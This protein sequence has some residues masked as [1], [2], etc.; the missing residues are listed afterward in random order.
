MEKEKSFESQMEE[1]EK[2]V[3]ELE[4][5]ELNLEDSVKKFEEG[6]KISKECNNLLENA[7]K[8]ISII[9]EKNEEIKEEDF[10][11]EE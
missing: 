5:G 7:E 3:L 9:L 11:T 2:I 4:K 6:M 1:L 8:R 10:S